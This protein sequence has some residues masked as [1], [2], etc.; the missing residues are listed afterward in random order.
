MSRE[1][2]QTNLAT[3]KGE[4]EN[5]GSLESLF[6]GLIGLLCNQRIARPP[7][8][9]IRLKSLQTRQGHVAHSARMLK[10]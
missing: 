10:V 9:K 2:Q 7:A 4:F 1:I 3:K 6:V 8:K 5:S